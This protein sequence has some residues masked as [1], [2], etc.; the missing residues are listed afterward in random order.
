ME[1]RDCTWCGSARSIEHDLCQ[2]CLTRS[3]DQ[4]FSRIVVAMD[5][6]GIEVEEGASP[7]REATAGE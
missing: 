7:A 2:V 5:L 1:P 4:R 3:A 6:A